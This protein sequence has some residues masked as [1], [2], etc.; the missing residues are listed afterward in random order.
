MLVAK[1]ELTNY[2]AIPLYDERKEEQRRN[3]RERILRRRKR[4]K[5]IFKLAC[6]ASI[7]LFTI[8][9]FFVLKGYS[10]ISQA[11]M[12]ITGL[13]RRRNELEQTKFSMISELE[14]AKSSV[15]I[16]EDAMY[17]LSM[18]YPGSDQVVY[19]S[20]GKSKDN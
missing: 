7:T 15:K 5:M 9:S 11:R 4:Q 1:S 14:E 6:I 8:V 17:K 16:S 20:L 13:E 2:G 19:I 3:R 12:D 18:D 10:T